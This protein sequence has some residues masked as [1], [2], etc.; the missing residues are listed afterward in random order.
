MA[1]WWSSLARWT[2]LWMARRWHLSC[3]RLAS[4]PWMSR[5]RTALSWWSLALRTSRPWLTRWSLSHSWW[6]TLTLS[7]WWSSLSRRSLTLW[8]AWPLT[9]ALTSL[10]SKHTFQLRVSDGICGDTKIIINLDNYK[11]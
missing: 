10:L 2:I 9:H 8:T 7:R 4:S 3:S 11:K 1:R 6:W 5:R